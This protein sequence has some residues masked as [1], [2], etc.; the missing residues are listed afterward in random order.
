ML[1]EW[2]EIVAPAQM[3]ARNVRLA[4]SRHP[5]DFRIGRDHRARYVF[6]LDADCAAP[7]ALELPRMAALTCDLE[8]LGD[9]RARLSL[10]LGH[11]ADFRN[12][13]LMC[14]GLMLATENLTPG[15]SAQG[16]VRTLDEVHHWQEM[17]RRRAE[18]KLSKPERIGLV[19]ELLFLRDVLAE[20]FDWKTAIKCWN[21]PGGDEQDFVVGS[22]IFEVKTQVVTA[23]RRI[24]ISSEDQL[25]PVQGR[26]LICNQGIAPLPAGDPAGR[27]LNSLV[28]ELRQATG[29]A[30]SG[31]AELLDLALLEARY[32]ERPEYEE[33]IWVLVDRTYYEVR[34]DFPRIERGE[35]RAGVD[36]VKYKIR[37]SDC[38]PYTVDVDEAFG[39]MGNE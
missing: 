24:H 20:R 29:V 4:D 3:G 36:Q 35:L 31:S 5:L 33:E 15:Q 38:V 16:L 28:S 14:T 30:G 21:G 18:K 13:S 19:G 9:G 17:L 26:I 11:A 37:V 39:G 27:T 8:Q 12:F 34:D 25:D 2:E 23:D 1:S 6:Q 10:V 32:E 7:C 22:S